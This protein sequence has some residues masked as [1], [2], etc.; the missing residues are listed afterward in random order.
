M[1]ANDL[2]KHYHEE[3]ALV[4]IKIQQSVLSDE[5]K[6]KL[7]KQLEP[8]ETKDLSTLES[9]YNEIV[10]AQ[11]S[12]SFGMAGLYWRQ[13]ELHY[14]LLILNL[15]EDNLFKPAINILKDY[16]AIMHNTMYRLLIK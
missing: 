2:S 5:E 16:P 15:L 3:I 14:H 6:T 8:L 7:L 12:V 1:I 13:I 4:Q 9:F 10:F 11:A